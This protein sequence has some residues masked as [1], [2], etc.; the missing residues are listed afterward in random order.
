MHRVER[1]NQELRTLKKNPKEDYEHKFECLL[2]K[3]EFDGCEE[4]NHHMD[5]KHEGR[6]KHGDPDVI[7][8]GDEYDESSSS[9]DLESEDSFENNFSDD[10][11]T[12]SDQ[13]DSDSD[14]EA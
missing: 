9:S 10:K 6:W 1:G 3:E 11:E 4:M 8:E 5:N 12:E 2:C 14:T 7:S 13:G